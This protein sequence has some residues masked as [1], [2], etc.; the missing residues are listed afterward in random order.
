VKEGDHITGVYIPGQGAV[1]FH[2]DQRTGRLD[3]TLAQAFFSIW[4]DPKTSEP[5]LRTALIGEPQ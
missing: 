1:F 2:N 3:Q 5:D 4:L